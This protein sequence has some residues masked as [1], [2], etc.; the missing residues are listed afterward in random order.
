MMKDE[1]HALGMNDQK[2]TLFNLRTM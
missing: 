2:V 1:Q